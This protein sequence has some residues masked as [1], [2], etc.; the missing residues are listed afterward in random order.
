MKACT[1]QDNKRVNMLSTIHDN[2][3][4]HKQVRDKKEATGFRNV[5]K[6]DCVVQYN[7]YMGGVDLMDQLLQYYEYP[8][9]SNK[10]YMPL[11]NR[12]RETAIVNRYILYQ[13]VHNDKKMTHLKFRE[14]LIDGLLVKGITPTRKQRGR[15]SDAN[16]DLRLV[17]RHLGWTPIKNNKPNCTV[18]SFPSVKR[19]QTSN[20]CQDCNKPIARMLQG[21]SYRAEG[22]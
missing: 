17:E 2:G 10:W 21:L 9:R 16:R 11:Y 13:K 22:G 18:C 19:L 4:T 8:H 14:D 12:I 3:V 20:G 15:P 5:A 1:W 7:K 6:P